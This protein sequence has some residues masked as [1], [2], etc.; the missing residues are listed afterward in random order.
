MNLEEICLSVKLAKKLKELNVSQESILY[1]LCNLCSDKWYLSMGGG[2][3]KHYHNESLS[4]FTSEE[5]NTYLPFSIEIDGKDHFLTCH[6]GTV[7]GRK[8]TWIGYHWH[9]EDV[10][11]DIIKVDFDASKEVDAKAKMLIYLIDQGVVN[12]NGKT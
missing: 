5:L 10:G 7:K 2:F 12:I 8:S 3:N 11:L 6:M 1:W 9:D 4:A